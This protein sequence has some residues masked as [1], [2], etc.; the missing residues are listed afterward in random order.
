M[1]Q[2][3]DPP[4]PLLSVIQSEV[5]G[6]E[7]ARK[8]AF[9]RMIQSCVAIGAGMVVVALQIFDFDVEEAVDHLWHLLLFGFAL[10][11][12]AY[13]HASGRVAHRLKNRIIRRVV[14]LIDENLTYSPESGIPAGVF[15]SS[16]LYPVKFDV[17]QGEDLIA[18]K[19][20]DTCIQFC[21]LDVKNRAGL[22]VS[23]RDIQVFHGL[24]MDV[25]RPGSFKGRTIVLPLESEGSLERALGQLLAPTR[26]PGERVR[27]DHAEFNRRFAVFSDAP[28][29]ARLLLTPDLLQRI[30]GFQSRKSRPIRLSFVGNRVYLAIEGDGMFEP[31][32]TQAI[33]GIDAFV[34][35]IRF[36]LGVAEDLG[37]IRMPSRA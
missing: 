19:M 10:M 1:Q 2:P 25:T 8:R 15:R 16:G 6:L 33:T 27:V 37:L 26:R 23:A 11:G 12:V 18:W 22:V 34:A 32:L 20:G 30:V 31:D 14:K 13:R 28:E 3:F 9:R 4:D 17:Y 7:A 29:E 24:F 5:D 35:E 21:D 36:A